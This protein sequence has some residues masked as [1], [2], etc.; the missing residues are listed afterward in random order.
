M[1]GVSAVGLRGDLGL[2]AYGFRGD[3]DDPG[4]VWICVRSRGESVTRSWLG[5]WSSKGATSPEQVKGAL[6]D[7]ASKIEVAARNGPRGPH[8][9]GYHFIL[10]WDSWGIGN[11]KPISDLPLG[12]SE[13]GSISEVS[14]EDLTFEP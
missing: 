13:I 11:P 7:L 8:L 12:E 5:C 2:V 14:V 9:G 4:R 3:S 1:I 6:A 10:D